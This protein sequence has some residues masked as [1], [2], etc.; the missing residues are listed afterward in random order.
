MTLVF[1][2]YRV[3]HI[4]SLVLNLFLSGGELRVSEVTLSSLGVLF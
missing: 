2:F 1:L 4:L 3:N